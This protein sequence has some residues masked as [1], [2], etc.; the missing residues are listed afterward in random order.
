MQVIASRQFDPNSL[1]ELTLVCCPLVIL[2]PKTKMSVIFFDSRTTL[3][4]HKNARETSSAKCRPLC[5]GLIVLPPG[6]RL[7]KAYDVTIQRYRNS[8][9]K[10]EDSKMHIL[11]CMGSKFCV[12]FQ[13]CPLKFHT[14]F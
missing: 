11:R 9:A 14:R 1:P 4:S 3:F 2:D 6:A 10:T 7:T 12:K 8:H 5:S 13:R